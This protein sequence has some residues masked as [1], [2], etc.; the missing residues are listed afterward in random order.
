MVVPSR[1]RA[2]YGSGA[3]SLLFQRQGGLPGPKMQVAV[4]S[5]GG[6]AQLGPNRDPIPRRKRVGNGRVAQVEGTENRLPFMFADEMQHIAKGKDATMVA[7]PNGFVAVPER[8][9]AAVMVQQGAG[10][11]LLIRHRAVQMFR[12]DRQPRIAGG[13]AA[14][15]V[16]RLPD[17]GRPATVAALELWPEFDPVRVL[18]VLKGDIRFGQTQLFALIDTDRTTQAHDQRRIGARRRRVQIPAGHMPHHVMVGKGPAGPAIGGHLIDLGKDL[19]NPRGSGLFLAQ[20]LKGIAH[21]HACVATGIL[22]QQFQTTL[23]VAHLADRSRARKLVQQP[24]ESRQKIK[25]LGLVLGV[26][27]FLM[28]IWVHRGGNVGIALFA[29][30]GRVAAQVLVCKVKVDRVEAETIHAPLQPEPGHIQQRILHVHVVEIQ[31]RLAVQEI[32]QV[33]LLARR[34]PR[35]GRAAKDRQPVVGRR[36]VLFGIGPDIPIGFVIVPIQL[37]GLKP[38]VLVAGMAEDQIDHHLDAIAMGRLDQ[39]VKVAERAEHRV[40]VAIVADVIAKVLH[41]RGK[42]G[43]DPDRVHAQRRDMRHPAHD[44]QQIADA[45]A[46]A[47][48]KTAGIDLIDHGPTPPIKVDARLGGGFGKDLVHGRMP[49]VRR[50]FDGASQQ[51]AYQVFLHGEENEQRHRNRH[52]CRC[53]EDLPIA[54]PCAQQVHDL[55]GHHGGLA[56]AVD[57]EHFGDKQVVPC[58]QEL[59][60]G[61]GR[62]GR[63]RQWEDDLGKDLEIRRPVHLGVLNNVARQPD[64]VVAQ[65][66]NGERQA[67]S[68]MGEPRP[69]IAFA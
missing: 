16:R 12:A 62:Q 11:S 19:G 51:A 48:L 30:Q 45:V 67:K 26:E 50:L 22:A 25:V 63:E 35:P 47:V 46:V 64:H 49:L 61:K 54:A 13:K 33:I 14:I 69:E 57:Q 8:D 60:D 53:G 37:G 17:H 28:V 21:L 56:C 66:V 31:V 29:G 3:W 68:D 55:V 23:R 40:N 65:E 43:R 18:Q 10:L 38:R 15:A 59:E 34:F 24:P 42:E 52:E 1:G 44:A 2:P 39:R 4:R 9:R 27:M 58:P 32:V 7:A 36:A 6:A 5:G 41:R 20:K